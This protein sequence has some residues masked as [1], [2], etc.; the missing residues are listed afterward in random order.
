MKTRS[1]LFTLVLFP[2]LNLNLILILFSSVTFAQN[3]TINKFHS[4]ITIHEDS[5]FIVKETIDVTFHSAKAWDLSG[6][7]ISIQGR[8]WQ[9]DGDTL[10]GALRDRWVRK[11]MEIQSG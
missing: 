8:T 10:R 3:F 2:L 5:S 9:N 11:I 4:D 1:K 7:P 6:D